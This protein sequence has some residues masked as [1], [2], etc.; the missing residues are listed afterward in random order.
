MSV[1]VEILKLEF[2]I[3]ESSRKP[4]CDSS[5]RRSPA[6][7]TGLDEPGV[8]HATTKQTAQER[9]FS[10]KPMSMAFCALIT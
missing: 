10:F 1:E 5:P 7:G 2:I 4:H 3:L 9:T 8:P 6:A